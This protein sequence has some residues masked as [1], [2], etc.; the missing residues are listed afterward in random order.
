MRKKIENAV[1][2]ERASIFSRYGYRKPLWEDIAGSWV[3]TAAGI[4]AMPKASGS[5]TSK[6]CALP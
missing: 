5:F 3:M 4:Y 1:I 2:L 6:R